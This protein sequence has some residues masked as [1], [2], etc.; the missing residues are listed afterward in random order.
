ML[1]PCPNGGTE[2]SEFP[3]RS[4]SFAEIFAGLL[5]GDDLIEIVMAILHSGR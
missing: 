2:V 4:F 1:R 5:S 3:R